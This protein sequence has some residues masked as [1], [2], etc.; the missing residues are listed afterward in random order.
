[1]EFGYFAF[2]V[3]EQ[4]RI[5]GIL[6][7]LRDDDI[8]AIPVMGSFPRNEYPPFTRRALAMLAPFGPAIAGTHD[9]DPPRLCDTDQVA[10]DRTIDL[11]SLRLYFDPEGRVRIDLGFITLLD[12]IT[13]PWGVVVLGQFADGHLMAHRVRVDE[14]GEATTESLDPDTLQPAGET[15]EDV[16]A[17]ITRDALNL[18]Y[19]SSAPPTRVKVDVAAEIGGTRTC[20]DATMVTDPPPPA[21][22]SEA[23]RQQRRRLVDAALA[24]DSFKIVERLVS[25][26]GSAGSSDKARA[27]ALRQ[28]ADDIERE[29]AL[30][31][32][33]ELTGS[34]ERAAGAWREAADAFEDGKAGR[35][36]A[37]AVNGLSELNEALNRIDELIDPSVVLPEFGR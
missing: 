19:Q 29:A 6:T 30:V 37:Q 10:G 5:R 18:T 32:D 25:R 2:Q 33:P 21:T 35:G 12:E 4:G 24:F 1:V 13:S 20:D 27:Q 34:A 23:D 7:S 22:S 26:S 31:D 14:D 15:P 28:L 3:D 11:G 8:F 36:R 9:P 17:E 16:L